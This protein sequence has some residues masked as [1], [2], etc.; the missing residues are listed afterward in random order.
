MS[1]KLSNNTVGN[2]KTLP[3]MVPMNGSSMILNSMGKIGADTAVESW[4]FAFRPFPRLGHLFYLLY[5]YVLY[6]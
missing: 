2:T 3:H 4:L 5:Y 1:K 6:R